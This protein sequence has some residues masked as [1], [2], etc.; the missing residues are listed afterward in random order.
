M[1]NKKNIILGS[2]ILIQILFFITWYIWEYNKQPS[3]Q[4]K[5]ILEENSSRISSNRN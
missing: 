1:K 2:L 4:L 5:K 3:N